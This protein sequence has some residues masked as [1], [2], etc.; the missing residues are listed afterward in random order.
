MPFPSSPRLP[1]VCAALAL[2]IPI[3]AAHPDESKP[4][5]T[6]AYKAAAGSHAVR[7][8]FVPAPAP[9]DARQSARGS[10]LPP[11]KPHDGWGPR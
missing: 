11:P 6:D 7:L 5:A 1:V 9:V 4:A 8:H 3:H 10:V 2:W